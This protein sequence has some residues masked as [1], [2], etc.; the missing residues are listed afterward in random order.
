VTDRL[1]QVFTVGE[2]AK[3]LSVTSGTIYRWLISGRLKGVKPGGGQRWRV[4]GKDV[5]DFLSR[6]TVKK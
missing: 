3:A 4:R 6:Y 1:E 5:Q 2:T